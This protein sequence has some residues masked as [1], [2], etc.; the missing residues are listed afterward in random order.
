MAEA[1][2]DNKPLREMSFEKS[3]PHGEIP[4]TLPP[5]LIAAILKKYGNGKAIEEEQ[6]KP[7]FDAKVTSRREEILSWIRQGKTI[8]RI[9]KDIG[10]SRGVIEKYIAS[11]PELAEAF[12]DEKKDKIDWHTENINNLANSDAT[13]ELIEGVGRFPTLDARILQVCFNAS[14]FYLERQGK[15][16]GWTPKLETCETGAGGRVPIIFMG[17]ISDEKIAESEEM[18]RQK[19]LE[20]EQE[21]KGINRA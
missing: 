3:V 21:L 16:E 12:A 4:K 15:A 5:S 6:N 13:M 10:V 14:K 17:D 19:N 1:E 8:M 9:H 2:K 7:K 18:I 11:D 20:I